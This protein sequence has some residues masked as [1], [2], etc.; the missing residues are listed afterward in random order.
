MA[1]RVHHRERTYRVTVLEQDRRPG[2]V[3]QGSCNARTD[4]KIT[5]GTAGYVRYVLRVCVLVGSRCNYGIREDPV[6]CLEGTDVVE[7]TVRED[8]VGG[9]PVQESCDE[10]SVIARVN[11]GRERLISV[12]VFHYVAVGLY[13][14]HLHASDCH[15]TAGLP[16]PC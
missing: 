3:F 2:K 13:Q 9:L 15:L 10:L 14:T 16:S 5:Q 4:I 11:H 8:Y 1:R 7:M 6:Q 12:R